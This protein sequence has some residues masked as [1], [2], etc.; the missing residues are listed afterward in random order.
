MAK[1]KQKSMN[2]LSMETPMMNLESVKVTRNKAF[3][4]MGE[5]KPIESDLEVL[6]A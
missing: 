2:K 3:T 5:F 6:L 4:N 1:M